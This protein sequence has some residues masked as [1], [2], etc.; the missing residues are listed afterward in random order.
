MSRKLSY[1]P[2]GTEVI[3]KDLRIAIVDAHSSN[4]RV[5]VRYN[6]DNWPFPEWDVLSRCQLTEVPIQYE[7]A[8]F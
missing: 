6:I 5:H 1:L 2:M 3:T 4:D 8:P 7:D